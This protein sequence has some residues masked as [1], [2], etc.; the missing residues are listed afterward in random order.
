[1]LL[2]HGGP[3]GRK[4][5]YLIVAVLGLSVIWALSLGFLK[6]APRKFTS[7]MTLIL[8]GTG[9]ASAVSLERIGQASTTSSSPFGVAGSSPAVT[10]KEML[11]SR[12]V[13]T[14]AA[15][16][17]GVEVSKLSKPRAKV[18]DQT[19]LISVQM[20]GPSAVETQKHLTAV[21][22]GFQSEL[23]RLHRDEA[24]QHEISYRSTIEGFQHNVEQIRARILAHQAESGLVSI[25]QYNQ[26]VQSIEQLNKQAAEITAL[27]QQ[28]AGEARKLMAS[29]GISNQ[30]AADALALQADPVFRGLL[31]S[32]AEAT[33]KLSANLTK[34]GDNH[35]EVMA[36]RGQ[37]NAAFADMQKR[38]RDLIHRSD[39]KI[40]K[41]LESD[42]GRTP[43]E[44]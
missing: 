35:A 16:K 22:Q 23:D 12:E 36:L 30:G 44:L 15:G 10:D 19:Q 40:L 4:R 8:P 6:Y 25:D 28:K 17:I 32:F 2:W 14:V 13:L 37:R 38:A 3:K 11:E 43:S 20:T 26:T 18:I 41:F 31:Q 24:D 1:M 27:R 42:A 39:L 21:L 5:R 33:Q 9:V 34:W 29:L 7:E